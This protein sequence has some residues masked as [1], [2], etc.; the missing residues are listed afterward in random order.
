M[1][2]LSTNKKIINLGQGYSAGNGISIDDYVIS[3]T[4]NEGQLYSAGQNI[5]IYDDQ[6]QLYI[7]GKDWSADIA[8][9]SSNAYEQA[10]ALI[11]P[12]FDP[13][14]ISGV[15]DNKLD[16]TAFSTV[17]GDY[18]TTSYVDM[19]DDLTYSR[20]TAWADN[21]GYLKEHQPISA[22][23]W[24]SSYE[25]VLSNSAQ[26]GDNT[27]D[28]EVNSF[29]YNN[30]A[31]INDVNTSYIQNSGTFLTAHQVI[32]SA[33]WEDAS[34]VVQSNS[35]QWSENTGDE[36]VNNAVYNNSAKWNDITVYQT[37]SANYLTAHQDLS[38]YASTGD[39]NAT[40]GILS[41]AIDYLS[42][43]AGKTYT[44]ISP[45]VVN[46]TTNEISADSQDITFG[47]GLDFTNGVLTVTAGGSISLP[48]TGS[49]NNTTATYDSNSAMFDYSE[50]QGEPTHIKISISPD[51]NE[52][53]ITIYN[54]QDEDETN[55][56]LT[57]GDGFIQFKDTED[58]YNTIYGD[59]VATWDDTYNTVQSNSANWSGTTYTGDAQGAVDEVYSNSADWNS[60]YSTVNANSG[61][62]TNGGFTGEVYGISGVSP[63][64]DVYID[65]NTLWISAAAGGAGNPEVESYVQTNSASIDEVVSTYETNSGTYLT[66][67]QDISNKLDTT[68]FSTVSGTFLTAHQDISANEWN[69]V[70]DTVES[71][72]GSWAGGG[73]IDTIPVVAISP[74][75]TGFSGESAYLGIEST[76]LNLSSYVPVSSLTYNGNYLTG[77]SGK[78]I[79]SYYTY[80]A[81]TARYANNAN[82]ANRAY[83][84]RNGNEIT[85]YYQPKLTIAGD[86]GTI[87]AINGS[88]VGANI[89]E[90]WELV[91]S[92]GISIV[93]DSVNNQTIIS[94]TG[95]GDL[96]NYYTKTETS[97]KIELDN[98][99]GDIETL[100]ASL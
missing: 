26:W 49:S 75:V 79:S 52:G 7:S 37:N 28:E 29:V 14:Y 93:D 12:E 66:A 96:S 36:E 11:P 17:S 13:S 89:P 33:K 55:S 8:N 4:G 81:Y 15:V 64:V 65:Q 6:G 61:T 27:G 31:T 34:D 88:A 53:G 42:G 70:Y 58:N 19:S 92:A 54:S 80:S 73:S 10:T 25:T 57:I 47:E 94:V 43:N 50:T 69:N 84:D 35:A 100:L 22:D 74:L 90:G 9:A 23:Q 41:G 44:G 38:D 32:P 77:V 98:A 67:H 85:S 83:G 68:A 5:D 60:N 40:S 30:S 1:G 91:G 72:S 46:N 21:Q 24:N 71:N 3:Y 63:N 39:L 82:T 18:A 56:T 62:W 97:S 87:T 16:S 76:A 78:Q 59:N 95:G 51:P 86:A 20:A 48:I 45:I 99:I 2:I